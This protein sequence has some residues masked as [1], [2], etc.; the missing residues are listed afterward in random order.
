MERRVFIVTTTREPGMS[1]YPTPFPTRSFRQL[2]SRLLAP[3]ESLPAQ[4][5]SGIPS[6]G[7]GSDRQIRAAAQLAPGHTVCATAHGLLLLTYEGGRRLL[8]GADGLP[9]EDLT[10]V[11]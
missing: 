2:S 7:D 5:G 6:P 4:A 9:M 3:G 11:S 10:H 8:T 1:A